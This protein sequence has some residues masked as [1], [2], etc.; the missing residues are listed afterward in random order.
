MRKKRRGGKGGGEERRRRGE[1]GE[2]VAGMLV[3]ACDRLTDGSAKNPASTPR[4]IFTWKLHKDQHSLH[5]YKQSK[6]HNVRA[7]S[8]K[9]F[10]NSKN[11]SNRV[12]IPHTVS[13][14]GC[15][16]VKQSLNAKKF[17]HNMKVL[18]LLMTIPFDLNV[19]STYLL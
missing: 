17:F 11:A 9:A 19:L 2:E 12:P 8:I 5:L 15:P 7:E 14:S 10:A 6:V 4:S 1:R 13:L 16:L 18:L 3:A